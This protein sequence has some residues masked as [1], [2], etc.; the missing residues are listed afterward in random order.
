MEDE[1]V[2][3]KLTVEKNLSAEA[4]SSNLMDL[5]IQFPILECRLRGSYQRKLN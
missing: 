1:Y 4:S 2:H 3:L 5:H